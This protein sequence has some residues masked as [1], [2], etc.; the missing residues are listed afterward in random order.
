[1]DTQTD[2]LLNDGQASTE[3]G[4]D[5]QALPQKSFGELLDECDD[6]ERQ[7]VLEYVKDSIATR[8]VLRCQW[9]DDPDSA[10]VIGSRML[11]NVKVLAAKDAFYKQKAMSVERAVAELSDI[12]SSSV[13]DYL[14]VKVVQGRE[15][16]E[17]LVTVLLT[18]TRNRIARLKAFLK[19]EKL[20]EKGGGQFKREI[21][22]LQLLCLD[23]EAEIEQYGDDVTRWVQGKPVAKEIV[24]LDTVKLAKDKERGRVKSW[25]PTEHGVKVEM[26]P[27]DVNL[28]RYLKAIGKMPEKVEHSGPDGG[29]IETTTQTRTW[30]VKNHSGNGEPVPSPDD[31]YHK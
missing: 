5:S 17:M 9:T 30:I 29:P 25:T 6:R 27:A 10:A 4:S 2:D 14:V 11:R 22:K 3:P 28:E 19:A 1:M 7:F 31:D 15:L 21:R 20:E 23:Y 26:Y 18:H 24:E 13:N 12:A 16:T 8:A